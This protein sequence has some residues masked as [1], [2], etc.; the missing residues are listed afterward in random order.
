V[1]TPAGLTAALQDFYACLSPG[2]LLVIQNRNFDAV[3]AR[4]ER[5]MEPQSH[6][7]ED[8]EWLFL[9]QYDYLPT[10]LI[11]FH[12]LTLRR[13]AKGEWHQQIH[14]TR[15]LPLLREDLV[16][17]LG[18]TGFVEIETFGSLD[19]SPFAPSSSGNLVITARKA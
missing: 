4:R 19:G 11:D 3:M 12:I 15:L 16:A 9:R 18:S 17:T 2:A 13:Q 14:S 10:G 8:T 7:S 1:L 6:R 5:W